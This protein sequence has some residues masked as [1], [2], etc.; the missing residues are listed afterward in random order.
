MGFGTLNVFS[1]FQQPNTGKI[2]AR[3]S[4][5]ITTIGDAAGKVGTTNDQNWRF[6]YGGTII[7]LEIYEGGGAAF[8][9]QLLA[10]SDVGQSVG[11]RAG[12]RE[13]D[14]F[15][16]ISGKIEGGAD[17]Y[18]QNTIMSGIFYPLAK[19]SGSFSFIMSGKIS[20]APKDSASQILIIS[21][22]VLSEPAD[23]FY[24][25]ITISGGVL[26]SPS[27]K[28]SAIYTIS[29]AIFSGA[30][31]REVIS[32]RIS[33]K[34][35]PVNSDNCNLSYQMLSFSSADNKIVLEGIFEDECPINY[36]FSSYIS[37]HS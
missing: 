6:P 30:G 20:G 11:I 3:G 12:L 9:V 28:Q 29:G 32:Q 36:G 10:D 13:A 18:Y 15:S 24:N 7:P 37:N 26:N 14:V 31:E 23:R 1:F 19:D 27:E 22:S 35:L 2:P 8:Q 21:G 25:K 17:R 5:D 33:G 4:Y 16:L 34:F